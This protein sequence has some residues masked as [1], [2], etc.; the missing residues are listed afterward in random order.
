MDVITEDKDRWVD[1]MMKEELEMIKSDKK[2]INTALA[3]FISF[4]VIGLIPLLSYVLAYIV[5]IPKSSLFA[6]AGMLTSFAFLFIGILK[7]YV[8]KTSKLRGA[9]E[10]LLLG[11]AAAILAYFVGDLLEKIIVG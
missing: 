8:T 11:A 10:T 6:I 5:D 7:S 4:F 2:P 9:F 3:T 1:V